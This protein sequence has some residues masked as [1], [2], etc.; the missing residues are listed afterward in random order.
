MKLKTVIW[1]LG[2]MIIIVGGY[3]FLKLMSYNDGHGGLYLEVRQC[4]N[5]E[6]YMSFLEEYFKN[7]GKYPDALPQPQDKE[8]VDHTVVVDGKEYRFLQYPMSEKLST[9]IYRKVND[10][11]DFTFQA[12]NGKEFTVHTSDEG[13]K[14]CF[15]G[16]EIKCLDNDFICKW[17]YGIK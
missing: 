9:Y 11:F 14:L 16:I 13:H 8:N 3:V 1:V 5:V 6:A 7:E 2:I 12:P 17:H 4:G 10:G 15:L